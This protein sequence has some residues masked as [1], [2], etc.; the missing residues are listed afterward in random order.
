MTSSEEGIK[1]ITETKVWL[2]Q[3]VS[4]FVPTFLVITATSTTDLS[5]PRDIILHSYLLLVIDSSNINRVLSH[6]E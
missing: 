1:V 5:L 3:F 6:H 2:V 4:S